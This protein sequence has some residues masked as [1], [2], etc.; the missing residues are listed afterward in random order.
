VVYGRSRLNAVAVNGTGQ[1]GIWPT[2]IVCLTFWQKDLLNSM[3]SHTI[4][5]GV[6]RNILV[7]HRAY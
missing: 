6:H 4:N 5:H 1:V 7:C 3:S 2:W